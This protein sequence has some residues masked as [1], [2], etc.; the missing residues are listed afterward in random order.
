[1]AERFYVAIQRAKPRRASKLGS[2]LA[3]T[4]QRTMW[5]QM[6]VR[7]LRHFYLRCNGP[8]CSRKRRSGAK[9]FEPTNT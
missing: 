4:P 2:S 9:M 6:S 5:T 1:M 8:L 7:R 3:L